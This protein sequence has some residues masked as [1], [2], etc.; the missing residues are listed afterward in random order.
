MIGLHKTCLINIQHLKKWY[1]GVFAE[2]L[3]RRGDPSF[4]TSQYAVKSHGNFQI[5]KSA[6]MMST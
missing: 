1:I 3:R 2:L 4:A 6:M 5:R